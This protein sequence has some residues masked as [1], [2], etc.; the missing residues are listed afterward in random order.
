MERPAGGYMSY[1]QMLQLAPLVSPE[2]LVTGNQD[3][4]PDV[5]GKSY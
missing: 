5:G 3:R 2:M 1:E 4:L